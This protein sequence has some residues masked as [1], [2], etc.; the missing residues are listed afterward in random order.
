MQALNKACEG[1]RHDSG[2]TLVEVIIASAITVTV[3]GSIIYS[4]ATG[5]RI[6]YMNAQQVAAFGLCREKLEEMR[7]M[8]YADV[9]GAKFPKETSVRIGHLG[10]R[11]GIA[12][13]GE[14]ECVITPYVSGPA[15]KSVTVTVRWTYLGKSHEER[16]DGAIYRIE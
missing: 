12:L 16:L 4:V 1:Q 14:R 11:E 13:L 3:L 8:D 2:V 5:V 6:N 7:D 9:T 10:G 15:G